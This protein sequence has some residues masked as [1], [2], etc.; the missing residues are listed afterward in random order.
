M[1]AYT[2]TVEVMFATTSDLLPDMQP[3]TINEWVNS[4]GTHPNKN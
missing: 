3:D 4:S 1:Y 2:L